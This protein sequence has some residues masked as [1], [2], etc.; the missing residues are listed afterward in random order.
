MQ[1]FLSLLF[2][3]LSL[4]PQTST[5]SHIIRTTEKGQGTIFWAKGDVANPNPRNGCHLKAPHISR[6]LN[7][8]ELVIAHKTLPCGSW[9]FVYN[10]RTGRSVVARKTDWGP[11]NGLLDCSKATARAI[12]LNGLETVIVVPLEGSSQASLPPHTSKSVP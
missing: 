5:L 6:Y 10:P 3:L 8:D 11:R 1:I 7:D 2:Y 9:A 12:G 4:F